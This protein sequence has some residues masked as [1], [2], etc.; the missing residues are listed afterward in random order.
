MA[1]TQHQRKLAAAYKARAI[2]GAVCA[3][4]CTANGKL[5]LLAAPNPEGQRNRFD[6]SQATDSCMIS[7]LAP[8]WKAHGSGAFAFEVLETL[9]KGPDQTDADFRADL[10]VLRDIWREK[11]LGEGTGLY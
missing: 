11:L 6:F 2:E 1:K 8:D 3:V 9:E 4:R 7:A 5:L 10:E